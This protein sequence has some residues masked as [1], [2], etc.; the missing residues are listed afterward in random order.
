MVTQCESIAED[1]INIYDVPIA[2][3]S[4]G[5]SC[6][7]SRTAFTAIADSVTSLAKR[8]NNDR[9][10]N[11]EWDFS[12]DGGTFRQELLRNNDRD[13]SWYLDGTDVATGAEPGTSRPGTYSV[14][15]RMTTEKGKCSALL[16]QNITVFPLPTAEFSSNYVSPICPGESLR[17]NNT[18]SNPSLA[19]TYK[20]E[21]THSSSGFSKIITLNT[22]DTLV[23]FIN[24]NDTLRTYQVLLRSTTSDGCELVSG[25][26]FV[27]VY[28]DEQSGFD[29]PAYDFRVTNCSP[30][31]S[32]FFVDTNTRNLNPTQYS[33][34][35][36]QG[37]ALYEGYPVTRAVGDPDFNELAYTVQNRT[38]TDTD[39]LDG[40]GGDEARHLLQQ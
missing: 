7:G 5:N 13:F 36:Y 17:F 14:A 19:M 39:L 25:K 23:S 33:W 11:Y 26:R 40:T 4:V 1:T 29:D 28:P 34:S 18:S 16:A 15:L 35:L 20:L 30:W 2:G 3:F 6:E 22:P 12:Y 38:E 32:T 27:Q 37:T 9:V 8:V 10:I 24:P 21:I 31:T